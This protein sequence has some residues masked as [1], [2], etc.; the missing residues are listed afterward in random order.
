MTLGVGVGNGDGARGSAD[1]RDIG[2]GVVVKLA[3]KHSLCSL[4]NLNIYR[5]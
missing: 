4:C 2:V 5:I 3:Q 1:L